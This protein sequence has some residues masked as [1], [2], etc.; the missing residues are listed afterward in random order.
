MNETAQKEVL[1]DGP[2]PQTVLKNVIPSMLAALL[3]LLYNLADTFFIG[4][5]NND[6]MVASVSLATPV[7]LIFMALGNLF[8]V[9]GASVISRE[10][11]KGNR[12]RAKKVSSFCTWSCIAVGI[13][14]MILFWVFMDQLVILLGASSETFEYTRSYLNIVTGC[15]VFSMFAYCYSNLIRSEGKPTLAIMGTIVGNILNIILDPIFILVCGWGIKGAAVA[16]VIGQVTAALIYLVYIL[17]GKFTLSARLRDFT[18]KNKV[19]ANV[20]AIGIPASLTNLLM[21]ISQIVANSLIAAYGDMAVA[22]YGVAAK[23]RMCFSS[24][25]LGF[26]QGLQPMLAYY[27]GNNNPKKFKKTLVF[28]SV[29]SLIFFSILTV[30]C[31]IFTEPIVKVFLT[32]DSALEYGVIFT[33]IL[34]TSTWTICFYDVLLNTLQ[35]MGKALPSLIASVAR[36][37]IIYI[38]MLF[39]LRAA[40]GLNGLIWAQ[41]AA[42]YISWGLVLGMAISAAGKFIK[43]K[44]KKKAP[45]E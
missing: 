36:Q 30:L 41:P 12:E 13:V 28:T 33:R 18:V 11:G 45:G 3:M 39:I 29:F 10:L 21:S 8:G 40:I 23:I 27:Y 43:G 2:V 32:E 5:T 42:E 38:P 20:L 26:G 24:I 37:G 7:F 16:T 34:L 31:Y 1:Y 14:C 9:G 17:S 44:E 4:Q 19:C 25:G 15:G 35:G 6:Y 22:A